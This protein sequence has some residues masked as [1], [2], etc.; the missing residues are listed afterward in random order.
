METQ[1]LW[2]EE[3]TE[4]ETAELI[5]K[6]ADEVHKRKLEVPAILFFEMHKPISRLAG[7]AMIFFAPFIAPFVGIDN[8]HN[9]SRLLMESSNVERLIQE[10]EDR[11]S[12]SKSEEAQAS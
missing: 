3:L 6:V 10:I 11:E 8:V 9:Y 12:E 7:N 5:S 2:T 4:Q 1:A